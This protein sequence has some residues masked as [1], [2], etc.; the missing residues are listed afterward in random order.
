M[1][2]ISYHFLAPGIPIA[3]LIKGSLAAEVDAIL[4]GTDGALPID[5]WASLNDRVAN[6]FS[7]VVK[8]AAD[9]GIPTFLTSADFW[10]REIIDPKLK[11]AE[12]EAGLIPLPVSS[13]QYW[14]IVQGLQAICR[15]QKDYQQKIKTAKTV[16]SQREFYNQLPFLELIINPTLKKL[17]DN[18]SVDSKDIVIDCGHVD[19]PRY[20]PTD[21]DQQALEDGLVLLQYLTAKGHNNVK[22]GILVNE[23]YGFQVAEKTEVRKAIRYLHS[24]IKR[25]GSHHIVNQA[26]QKILEGYGFT[27][28]TLADKLVCS[29]EGSL[30]LRARQDIEAYERGRTH[31]FQIELDAHGSNGY[32]FKTE[33]DNGKPFERVIAAD[34]GAPVCALMSAELNKRYDKADV[35]RLIYLRDTKWRSG[36]VC[37]ARSAKVLYGTDVPI[38]AFFYGNHGVHTAIESKEQF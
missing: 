32:S 12:H 26:Y 21:E 25:N 7:T 27:A 23:M 5:I 18:I 17:A 14:G 9:Q 30:N 11:K 10:E 16:F 24:Q 33:L 19:S 15:D 34:S 28:E 1:T 4:V 6:P 35:G 37:G 20:M 38:D 29:F 31:P 22:I 13:Q 36:I 8:D 3:E 2:K